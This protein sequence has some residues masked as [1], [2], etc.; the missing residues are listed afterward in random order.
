MGGSEEN[1][2]RALDLHRLADNFWSDFLV[3]CG[4]RIALIVIFCVGFGHSSFGQDE[5]SGCNAKAHRAC[6]RITAKEVFA[7]G[8]EGKWSRHWKQTSYIGQECIKEHGEK[9]GRRYE[10][11]FAGPHYF[12][13]TF[14]NLAGLTKY[15]FSKKK[16]GEAEPENEATTNL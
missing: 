13:M 14:V 15:A 5:V 12:A 4:M 8:A 16:K 1:V 6:I 7:D 2:R 10:R 11:L 9:K 3:S